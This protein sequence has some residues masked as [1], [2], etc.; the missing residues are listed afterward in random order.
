MVFFTKWRNL[1]SKLQIK[2]V[3]HT[4]F[5]MTVRPALGNSS[6][7]RLGSR[8]H[9]LSLPNADIVVLPGTP[10][11]PACNTCSNLLT[12]AQHTSYN[13]EHRCY[14]TFHSECLF[15]LVFMGHSLGFQSTRQ[16]LCP[17]WWHLWLSLYHYLFPPLYFSFVIISW[18]GSICK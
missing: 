16:V 4:E 14:V 10:N 7:F 8:A 5:D 6:E 2:C 3:A 1:S 18:S 13:L 11:N 12:V 9:K 17:P 15:P